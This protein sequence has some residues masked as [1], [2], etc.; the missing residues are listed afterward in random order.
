LTDSV[1]SS[2]ITPPGFSIIRA[3]RDVNLTNKQKGGGLCLIINDKWCTNYHIVDSFCSPKLEYLVV[4]CRPFYLPREITCINFL[5]VYL[6]EGYDNPSVSKLYETVADIET[7]KPDSAIIV[8]GDFSG[9][10]LKLAGYHQYVDCSTRKDNKIDLCYCNIKDAYKCTKRDPLGISDHH[11]LVLSPNYKQ[12]L[13]QHKPAI[14][15]IKSWNEDSEQELQACFDCT[16]W[17]VF[18]D[19]CET[20]EEL[21]DVISDYIVFCEDTVVPSK[22]VKIYPNNKPW[23]GKELKQKLLSKQNILSTSNDRILLKNVQTDI[24]NAIDTCKYEFKRKLESQFKT[25]NTKEAWKGLELVT[26]Y[27]TGAKSLS[28]VDSDL[29]DRLNTFYTRFD[30]EDNSEDI[31]TVRNLINSSPDSAGITITNADVYK[32]F[33]SLNPR[34]SKGPDGISPKVLRICS[35]Q[36]SPIYTVIFQRCVN[37]HI[38]SIWKTATVIPVPK[39]TSPKELNDYRPISL[40]SVPFKTLERIVQEHLCRESYDILDNLQFSYQKQ[41]SVED[42]TLTY[43]NLIYEHLEKPNTYARTLFIDFSSAFNTI[44]PHLLIKKLLDIG[45]SPALCLF[46]L[47]FIT[48]RRQSVRIGNKVS[49]VVII[50]TGS[51]QGCVLSALLFILYTNGLVSYSNN[52]Y[53]LKYA[54]DTAIL[55][56]ITGN[57]ETSYMKEISQCVSWCEDNNLILNAKKTKELICDF[58]KCDPSYAPVIVAGSEVERVEKFKYLGTT[59]DNKLSWS[60]H[61]D[62]V[63]SKFQQRLYFLRLLRSFNIDNNILHMFYSSVVESIIMFNILTYWSNLNTGQK[64]YARKLQKRAM[65][66]TRTDI[67]C[68]EDTFITKCIKK[69]DKLMM[70]TKHPLS[71]YYITMRS[72][73][74]LRV[75]PCRSVRYRKSF[76]PNSIIMY[77]MS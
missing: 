58:R 33:K 50:N 40:T 22:A 15:Y 1:P 65:R 26:Q 13:K 21:V 9:A 61:F 2:A 53:V 29:S 20:I 76:I 57:D 49:S 56:L 44:K 34:K 68:I 43:T 27:K 36:L 51:P 12:K 11:V 52:C 23:F 42:A 8:L 19:S 47:D 74:R 14:K 46:V 28:D 16:D 63:T 55:G 38:P 5:I 69:V 41:R 75:P 39:K 17:E 60:D 64:I 25:N 31:E 59:I 37:E 77:N 70:D 73:K 24:N 48:E 4:R 54:D 3:D 67:I 45:I 30:T 71:Q 10:T 7:N 72:G 35:H 18:Y 62:S 32:L 66:I 6:P